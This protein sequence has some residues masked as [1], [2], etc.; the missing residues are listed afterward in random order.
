[1]KTAILT[2]AGALAVSAA[3]LA[4]CGATEPTDPVDPVD[5]TDDGTA[6]T[7]LLDGERWTANT[8]TRAILTGYGFSLFTEL[9]FEDRFPL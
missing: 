7:F 1:M 5:P 2:F 3:V 4:G 9:R 8:P 6:F